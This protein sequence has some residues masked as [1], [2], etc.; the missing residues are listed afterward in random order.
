M[1]AGS[2]DNDRTA[3]ARVYAVLRQGGWISGWELTSRARTTC[4]STRVSEVR[5]Q[6]PE[7]DDVEHKRKDGGHYY[8]LVRA[9]RVP[10]STVQLGL[11][12]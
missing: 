10:S 4:A 9:P 6:L 11:G 3:A 5:H 12:V 1:H 7:G 2:I 8:R